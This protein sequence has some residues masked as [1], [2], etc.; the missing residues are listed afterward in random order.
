VIPCVH[1]AREAGQNQVK[2]RKTRV[3]FCF[4]CRFCFDLGMTSEIVS[5]Q[6]RVKVFISVALRMKNRTLPMLLVT[7]KRTKI[8]I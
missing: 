8:T 2:K 6:Q 1:V 4:A 5:K 3:F 7:R